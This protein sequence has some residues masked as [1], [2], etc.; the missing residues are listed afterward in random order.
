MDGTYAR[1]IRK[2]RSR[3]VMRTKKALRS[4][5]TLESFTSS[6]VGNNTASAAPLN[7]ITHDVRMCNFAANTATC[8]RRLVSIVGDTA[9]IAEL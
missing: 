2:Q 3:S 8:V 6:A 7:N 9:T 1:C 5:S 4:F